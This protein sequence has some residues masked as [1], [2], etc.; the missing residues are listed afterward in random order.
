MGGSRSPPPTSSLS[1]RA[2]IAEAVVERFG[3][4]LHTPLDYGSQQWFTDGD[5]WIGT[6]APL[7]G[8]FQDVH[9]AG[10]FP[11]AGL[12]TATDPPPEALVEMVG[13]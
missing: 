9:G 12:W 8:R 3:G 1:G 13:A 5:P 4:Q 10:E 7:F 11:L 6:L 2:P